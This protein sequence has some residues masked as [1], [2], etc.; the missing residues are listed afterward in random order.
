MDL[1][2]PLDRTLMKPSHGKLIILKQN[3]YHVWSQAHKRFLAGRGIFDIVSETIPCP[4]EETEPNIT[5]W[6][7]INSWIIYHLSTHGSPTGCRHG[8]PVGNRHGSPVV[9]RHTEAL[10]LTGTR[11]PY[12]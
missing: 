4:S 12:G 8:S 6:L 1:S 10:W 2:E 7:L 5:N 11:K 3:N 9:N